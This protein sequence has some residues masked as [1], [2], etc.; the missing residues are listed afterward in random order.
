VSA[1][2]SPWRYLHRYL[3][4]PPEGF[5]VD[6]WDGNPL[7]NRREN[8]RALTRALNCQNVSRRPGLR[9]VF[10]ISGLVTRPWR[11]QVR[12]DGVVYYGGYF[13]TAEEARPVARALRDR[14]LSHV[15]EARHE[16]HRL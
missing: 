16:A 9:D 2:S 1:V 12:L 11:V 15:N 7:N 5:E 14:V 4:E 13:T 6:H 10:L 8:L 3:I